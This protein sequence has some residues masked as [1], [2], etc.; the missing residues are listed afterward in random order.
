MNSKAG[1]QQILQHKLT[2]FKTSSYTDK[3]LSKLRDC[4]TA[5]MG[6]H[7]HKCDNPDC[8]HVHYQYHGCRNR[9]CPTCNWLKQEE[10]MEARMNELLPVKYFHVVFT[11]AHELNSIALGNRIAF[12]N[13]LFDCASACLINLAKDPKWLGATPSITAILHTWGQQLTFHPHIHC[14]VSGGGVDNNLNWCNLKKKSE[15]GFLFPYP[16]MEEKFK[17]M[18]LQKLSRLIKNDIVK[19][20]DSTNWQELRKTLE[21]KEWIVYAKSPMGN[22]AQVVEYL[23]RYSHKV[24]ISNHR[25]TSIEDD[26]VNFRYKDYADDGKTKS[27]SLTHDEFIRRFREHILPKYF[28]KM[29]HY[30]ILTNRNRRKRVNAILAKMKLPLHPAPVK[31]PAFIRIMEKYG[32]DIFLCPKCKIGRFAIVD[33]VFPLNRGSPTFD[34][35]NPEFMT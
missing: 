29:R 27:M 4:R 26:R 28:V 7:L 5:T 14:I 23:A 25:I 15:K 2:D 6:Y 3:V 17:K 30:G 11:L 20:P 12:F 8:N 13:L 1:I 33:Q 24:A 16:V 18:F 32:T 10:W 34:Y 19:L 35:I 21:S 9:H 31:I 22:A